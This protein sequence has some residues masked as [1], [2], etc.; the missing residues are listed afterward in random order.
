MSHTETLTYMR[1]VVSCSTSSA[2][3]Y[4]V[5]AEC[6]LLTAV[7]ELAPLSPSSAGILLQLALAVAPKFSA[8]SL[9]QLERLLT[10]TVFNPA[11]F[12]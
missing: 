1:R 3:N 5:Y 8:A 9:S 12:K 2:R 4:F 11:L 7:C 6:N 10:T